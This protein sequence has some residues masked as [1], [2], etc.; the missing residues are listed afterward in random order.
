[1]IQMRKI[2]EVAQISRFGVVGVISMFC[3]GVS[4]VFWIEVI[5]LSPVV[6]NSIAFLTAFGVSYLG[7]Y[8]WTFRS[9]SDH[10]KSLPKFFMIAVSGFVLN[11][12]I[13]DAATNKFGLH[14]SWGFLMIV[15]AIPLLTYFV[16]R[17]WVFDSHS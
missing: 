15:V 3:H 11:G 1:M 4:L 17:F 16:S 13:M 12:I 10:A 2:E 7:H 14:Y 8:N 5:G 6:S 9:D